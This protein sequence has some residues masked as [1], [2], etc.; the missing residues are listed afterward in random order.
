MAIERLTTPV[1]ELTITAVPRAQ[2]E[3]AVQLE[4]E[5]TRV[6]AAFTVLR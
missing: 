3:G 5:T 1:E 4:W 2:G 6:S